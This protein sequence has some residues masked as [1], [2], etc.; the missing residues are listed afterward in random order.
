M[1]SEFGGACRDFLASIALGCREAARHGGA[2]STSWWS[3][4]RVM[5]EHAAQQSY[6]AGNEEEERLGSCHPF[7]GMSLMTRGPLPRP[8]FL[9]CHLL[10]TAPGLGPSLPDSGFGDMQHQGL[11]EPVEVRYREEG[12]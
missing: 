12:T 3:T 4:Q 7:K 2:R 11:A 1:R 8:R 5:V 6:S 9:R 10:P